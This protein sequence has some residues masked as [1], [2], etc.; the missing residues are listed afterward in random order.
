VCV[1]AP[2]IVC[3]SAPGLVC[4]SGGGCFTLHGEGAHPD[5]DGGGDW[6]ILEAVAEAKEGGGCREGDDENFM[7]GVYVSYLLLPVGE[8]Q[9][10]CKPDEL[11]Q[12]EQER[13]LKFLPRDS[14]GAE[15]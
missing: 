15:N 9:V 7:Q 4:V 13:L 14:A 1:S 11:R 8:G 12:A 3:G 6:E 5:N 2:S 10:E